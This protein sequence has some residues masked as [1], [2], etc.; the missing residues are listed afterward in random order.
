MN[1]EKPL[2]GQHN[3]SK[4]TN[5]KKTKKNFTGFYTEDAHKASHEN[6][7]NVITRVLID[8][9]ILLDSAVRYNWRKVLGIYMLILG[10]TYRGF[11]S[12]TSLKLLE[13]K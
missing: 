11:T 2:R 9:Q 8:R 7:G 12:L 3:R 13:W 4:E 5:S 1:T 10:I 6:K